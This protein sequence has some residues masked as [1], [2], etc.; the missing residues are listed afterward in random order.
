MSSP[1][2]LGLMTFCFL[3][4]GYLGVPV[5]FSLMAGVF[6]GALLSDVSLAA[7]IQKIFD[8]V[9]SEA[10]LAIPFFLLVGEL[11]SSANVVVRVANLSLALVGHIRGGLSQVVTVFSMFFSEM[12]G[13]TTADVAVISRALGGPMKKEGYDPAFIAAIV[14]AASTI[15]ALV[16]PSIT[17]VVYGAVGNVSIAGLFMAGA[18]PGLMIGFGLMIYCFFF[19]PP[20]RRKARAPFGEV[21]LAARDAALPMMIPVIL[22]GGI[23][24]G[25]FTPTEAGVVAVIWIIVVI[26]PAL[27]RGHLWALPYDFCMAGL[28][29][30]LP[31][32]TIG[33]ANAFGWM[34]AYMRGAIVIA[35]WITSIA[36]NDP[37]LIMLLLVA[38]FTIIGDFIE[39]VPTIIIFMPLVNTLTQVGDINP[40]HMG[41]VLIATLAFGLITPP[42]GLVLL[43]ASKF[44][45]VRFSQ[46]LRAALPIYVVFLVTIAFTIYFPSVVLWLPKQVIP[47]S[48]GCFKAPDGP[49]YIC[50]K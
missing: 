37:H 8:G 39:P 34:L 17:A 49:G 10:L 14:A 4:F 7:I 11:M 36:G 19:G 23:L 12:S 35:D 9:D 40:V 13:S 24:T 21:A 20:G 6:V 47:A 1:L 26:I 38:L 45:G 29:F 50:P 32:I 41:V 33:A 44:V 15:A 27:N 31:L 16:P 43:M 2:V 5:P 28:I 30:S 18:V 46:A 25:W 3:F 22:L 42:Y 48:V